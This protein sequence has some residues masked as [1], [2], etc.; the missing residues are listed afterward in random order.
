MGLWY[1]PPGS[2]QPGRPEATADTAAAR[3]KTDTCKGGVDP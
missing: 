3:T 1:R 2:A